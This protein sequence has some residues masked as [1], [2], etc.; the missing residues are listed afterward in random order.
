MSHTDTGHIPLKWRGAFF[1]FD[2]TY[3]SAKNSSLSALATVALNYPL[4]RSEAGRE[5]MSP[6]NISSE[7]VKENWSPL[8]GRGFLTGMLPFQTLPFTK[9]KCQGKEQDS[10]VIGCFKALFCEE[11]DLALLG[12]DRAQVQILKSL[13]KGYKQVRS[14]LLLNYNPDLNFFLPIKF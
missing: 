12:W 10:V 2:S 3:F 13:W 7:G 6:H 9:S 14:L 11:R 8:R 1:P 4:A 5:G